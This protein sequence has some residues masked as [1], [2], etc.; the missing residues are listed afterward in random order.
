M[1][2]S[3]SIR[4]RLSHNQVSYLAHDREWLLPFVSISGSLLIQGG[5]TVLTAYIL[6]I[7]NYT[8]QLG[9]LWEPPLSRMVLL[10]FSR[11]LAT[12]CITWL[13]IVDRSEYGENSR[14]VGI[15]DSIYGLVNVYIFGSVAQIT[16]IKPEEVPPPARLARAASALGLLSIILTNYCVGWY[17]DIEEVQRPEKLKPGDRREDDS[18]VERKRRGRPPFAVTLFLHGLRFVACWLLWAGVLFTDETA[19]CPNRKAIWKITIIWLFTPFA[20]GL[21]RGFLTYHEEEDEL[22]AVSLMAAE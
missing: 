10:W 4:R 20:D 9:D 1:L 17:K 2:G 5:A 13:S 16:N 15:V 3:R 12:V 8:V 21:W 19:F 6:K 14:E 22:H 11:P 18:G 7:S